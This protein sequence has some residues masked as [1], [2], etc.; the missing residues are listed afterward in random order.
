[1]QR[2]PIYTRFTLAQPAQQLNNNQQT[3]ELANLTTR[4]FNNNQQ[5]TS[6]KIRQST[7]STKTSTKN[8]TEDYIILPCLLFFVM[9]FLFYSCFL[10][11]SGF[12][13]CILF[14]FFFVSGFLDCF[15]V[16]FC[17]VF[18]VLFIF[19]VILSDCLNSFHKTITCRTH[20]AQSNE[21]YVFSKNSMT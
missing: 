13:T 18:S 21:I 3:Q 5:P 17:F 20:D 8:K 1:M 15:F 11:I 7:I 4:Q 6:P 14:L 2:A 12:V 9:C 10:F 19:F 16:C